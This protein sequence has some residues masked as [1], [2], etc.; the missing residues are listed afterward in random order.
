MLA[1]YV[2]SD[3]TGETVE[4]IVR[5]ALV[6]FKKAPAKVVRRG[7]VRTPKQLRELVREAADQNS[8]ILHTLVS[9][10]LRRLMLVESRLVGVDAMDLMGPT[11]DRLATHLGLTPQEKPGLFKQLV[12]DKSRQV[13]A[14]EFAFRHDDGQ[15]ADELGGAEVVL[16][17]VS[18]TMKTPTALY[19]AYKGWFAANVPI[20]PEIPLPPRLLSLPAERV[21]CLT[22]ATGRLLELRLVR[23]DRL[24][25]SATSYTSPQAI[26]REARH[27]R[28]VCADHGWQ[29]IDVTAKSVEEVAQEIVGLLPGEEQARSRE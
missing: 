18:R 25:I 7:H 3:A 20:I 27:C 21:F 6:Q 13:E 29:S 9:H 19:L 14:V 1:I 15:K 16:V 5:S 4:R 26:Q 12:E 17:G 28:L 23:A 24:E 11:L 8:L 22:M 2:V 10:E